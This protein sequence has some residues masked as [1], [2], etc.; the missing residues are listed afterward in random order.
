MKR[1]LVGWMIALISLVAAWA[2]PGDMA[3]FPVNDIRAGMKGVAYSVFAG[4]EPESFPVEVVGVLKSM[5]GPRQDIIL[6]RVAG[7]FEKAGV[8]AGMSGSPYPGT[9]SVP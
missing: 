2:A 1:I 7:R 6:V 4:T 3:T 9:N 8:A 5:W